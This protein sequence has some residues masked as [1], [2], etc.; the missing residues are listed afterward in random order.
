MHYNHQQHYQILIIM[1][2]NVV[3]KESIDYTN[4]NLIFFV[5][6]FDGVTDFLSFYL[7]D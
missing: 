7:F 6:L 2:Y 3:M 1:V 4:K 5:F